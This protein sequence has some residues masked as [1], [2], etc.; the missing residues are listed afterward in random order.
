MVTGVRAA[1]AGGHH[2]NASAPNAAGAVPLPVVVLRGIAI[3][4][5]TEAETVAYILDQLDAGRGGWVVTH[6][7]DHLRRRLRYG[8]FADICTGASLVV[9]DG[10]P[11]VWASRL[12]RTPVPERVSGANLVSSLSAAA[13][14]R[15]RSV[16]LLGGATGTADAAARVLRERHSQLRIAGT[17]CPPMGFERDARRVAELAERLVA[18]GPDIIFVALG[19]PKQEELIHAL[20][21]RLP[22]AWWLGV[23]VSFSFISGHLKRAPVWMQRTGLEWAH[24]L[25][26]E[27][28]RLMRRYLIDGIPFAVRL[29]AASGWNGVRGAG[30]P[31]SEH[32]STTTG[33]SGRRDLGG[34]L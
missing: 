22:I 20:H 21:A 10:M 29:L 32:R 13:S 16:F 17:C 4:A 25:M 28:R 31:A 26:Q 33:T 24:R 30:I 18:A 3:H 34:R 19:S 2:L 8:G 14:N 7:S 9:A 1:A 6:N 15:G 23:G 27:P 12:Q 11:L 5:I